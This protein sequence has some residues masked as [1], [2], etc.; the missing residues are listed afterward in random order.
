LSFFQGGH[1]GWDGIDPGID[2][3]FDF[4]LYLAATAVFS[5]RAPASALAQV[6]RRDGLY[7][8]PD[9]LVTFLDNHDTPRL[10]TVPGVTP[11][12]LRLAIAFLLTCRGIP[13]ITWGDEIGLTGHMDDRRDFPGGFPGDSHDA[14]TTGGRRPEEQSVFATYRDLLRLRKASPAL[15]RGTL[16]ELV[17]NETVFAY[18][19]HDSSERVVVALNLGRTAAEVLLPPEV[20]GTAE[21]LHGVA[22]WVDTTGGPRLELPAESV[23]ILR[24]K[25]RSG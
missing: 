5:G 1:T 16:T 3:V 19:R 6:I 20:S 9:L 23:A 12:R 8:R 11:A 25:E 14:F 4:P 17:V 7:P 24:L 15:R 13:Q 21:R 10:A 22:Q 2:A 18:L